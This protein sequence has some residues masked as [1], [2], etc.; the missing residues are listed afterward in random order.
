[1]NEKSKASESKNERAKSENMLYEIEHLTLEQMQD[2]VVNYLDP[3]NV[4]SAVCRHIDTYCDLENFEEW[5]DM[6]FRHDHDGDEDVDTMPVAD[7]I[8]GYCARCRA[9]EM[10]LFGDVLNVAD[11]RHIEACREAGC[12]HPPFY[13]SEK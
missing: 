13:A 11:D 4:I 2:A 9:K 6:N 10:E 5:L 8:P 12:G 1:M 7:R 3:E